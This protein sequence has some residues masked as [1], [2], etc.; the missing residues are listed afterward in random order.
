MKP[1][2]TIKQKRYCRTYQI[3]GEGDEIFAFVNA[4]NE[5]E[6]ETEFFHQFQDTDEREYV[7]TSSVFEI[8]KND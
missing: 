2:L 7:W 1:L 6:A 4:E 3:D 5:D 8:N